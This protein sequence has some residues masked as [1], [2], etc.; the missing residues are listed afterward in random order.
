MRR[1]ALDFLGGK[2]SMSLAQLAAILARLR[3][4]ALHARKLYRQG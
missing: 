1:S 4:A 2:P 3:W